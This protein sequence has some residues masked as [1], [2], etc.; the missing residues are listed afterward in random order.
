MKYILVLFLMM[1]IGCSSMPVGKC[2]MHK[3]GRVIS[4]EAKDGDNYYVTTYVPFLGAY[5]IDNKIMHKDYLQT[6]I[7]DDNFYIGKC[8]FKK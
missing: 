3:D 4:L 5:F 8:V 2:L 1:F 7:D 6:F